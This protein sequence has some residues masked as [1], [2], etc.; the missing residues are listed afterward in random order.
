M[1]S[2]H[3]S[4]A[5]KMKIVVVDHVYL[6]EQHIGRLRAVG[7]V[8]IFRDPPKSDQE[9]KQRIQGNEIVIVGWSH[10]TKEITQRMCGCQR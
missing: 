7:E 10:L 1:G 3:Q 5:G 8:Q 6:E 4:W 9:L 2:T